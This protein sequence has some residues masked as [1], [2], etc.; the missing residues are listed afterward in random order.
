MFVEWPKIAAFPSVRKYGKDNGLGTVPYR[1][2]V[3]LHGTHDAIRKNS[4]GSL[5]TFSRERIITPQS[6]NFGFSSWVYTQQD[7]FSSLPRVSERD[8]VIY[9][10]W[11]GPGVQ[12]GVALAQLP[13]KIFAVFAVVSLQ[14]G[15]PHS[16]YHD[17]DEMKEILGIN[18]GTQIPA[19]LKFIPYEPQTYQ[20]NFQAFAD[21]LQ[22]G[23]LAHINNKVLAVEKCDPFVQR[24]FDIEGT[25]EGIV[26]YP[27][28]SED[29]AQRWDDFVSYGFKAK[30]T[31]HDAVSNKQPVVVNVE[32]AESIGAFAELVTTIARLEQGA[33]KINGDTGT[34]DPRQMSKFLQWIGDDILAECKLE[35]QETGIEPDSLLK[36]CKARAR[37]W[38]LTQYEAM[39]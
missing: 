11:C 26:L 38:Y 19:S 29:R 14:D 20:I 22:A 15:S 1:A 31:K 17:V 3:K 30:G 39:K 12:R 9:G 5:H 6:D 16:I 21:E 4:D 34:F 23:V 27:V 8:L 36:A 18:E 7:F 37:A 32:R 25:G 28:R 33:Q 35:I 2:K 10:E 13:Y 24:N